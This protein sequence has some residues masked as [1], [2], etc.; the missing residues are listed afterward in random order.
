LP[1]V[2]L[3]AQRTDPWVGTWKLNVAASTCSPGPPPTSSTRI[4]EDWGRGVF[5]TTVK[6]VNAQGDPT[7]GH[8]AFRCDGKDHPSASSTAPGTSPTFTT[9]AVER[10][11]SDT[12]EVKA[13]LDGKDAPTASTYSISK[14]G[15]PCTARTRGTNRQR[16]PVNNVV[17]WDRQ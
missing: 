17:V 4:T 7:W 8:A 9:I 12:L 11:D 2:V 15:K 10:I 1:L 3:S 13:K 6:G 14:D 16:Q 5:V